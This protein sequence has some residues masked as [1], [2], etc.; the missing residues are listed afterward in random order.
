MNALRKTPGFD[1]GFSFFSNCHL[2]GKALAVVSLLLLPWLPIRPA[3]AELSLTPEERAWLRDHPVL[4]HAPDP[5]YAPFEFRDADGRIAGMATDT[6][7]R[8]ARL[9]GVHVESMATRSWVH[10]LEMVK[11]RQADLVTVATPTEDRLIHLAFTR[12][13]AIFPDLLLLRQGAPGGYEMSWLAGKTLAGIEGWAINEAVRREHPEIRFR[14]LPDVKSVLTAVS[15][16]EVDGALLNRATAGYWTERLRITNLR[17]GGETPFV[18][19]LGL[20][21]R[22]DWPLLRDLLDKALEELGQEELL[23]IQARWSGGLHESRSAGSWLAWLGVALLLTGLSGGAWFMHRRWQ[24]RL[25][26]PLE[27]PPPRK[28]K[29][30]L[31]PLR[32]VRPLAHLH[33]LTLAAGLGGTL[34]GHHLA[35]E[36]AVNALKVDFDVEARAI[37]HDIQRR[38]EAYRRILRGVH[39][40]FDAAG[41]VD[42][43]A[44]RRYVAR[45]QLQENYPGIQ[46]LGFMP[47]LAADRKEDVVR[48]VREEGFADFDVWPSGE[49]TMHAPVLYLEPMEGGHLRAFGHDLLTEPVLRSA[50]EQARDTGRSAA[51]GKTTLDREDTGDNRTGFWVFFPIY[52]HDQ[53][54]ASV[55]ERRV[56]LVGW[57]YAA[58]RMRDLMAD[59][60]GA[61]PASFDLEIH[62]CA[63]RTPEALL[64]DSDDSVAEGK[65]HTALFTVSRVIDIAKR[66]WTILVSSRKEFEAGLDGRR[67][68][69]ILAGGLIATGLLTLVTWLL[70]HGERRARQLATRMTDRLRE[71]LVKNERLT[72]IMND[73]EAYIYI[74]DRQRRY[75]YANR[76]TLELFGCSAA[77]L[78]GKKDEDFFATGDQARLREVDERVLTTGA[79]SVTEMVVTPLQAGE[80]RVYL[81]AKRAI[82]DEAGAIWGLSGVSTD[83]TAQKQAERMLESAKRS[84]ESASRAKSEFLAAMSHEIR[85]PMNVVLGMSDLLLEGSLDPEQRRLVEVMHRSGRALL[86]VIN[87]VLDYSRLEAGRFSLIDAPFSPT[88]LVHETALLMRMAAEA[89]GLALV[90]EVAAEAP[91]RLMGDEGRLRQVLI[92]L[93]GNAVK[94]TQTGEIRL[95]LQPDP[96]H[97]DHLL[98]AV[99]DSGIGIAEEHLQRIFEHFTQADS[100]IGRRYGGTGLGLAIAHRLV[101]LM[102]GALGVE[103]QPG[104]GSRFHFSLPIRLAPPAEARPSEAVATSQPSESERSLRILLAEDSP[105]N[106]FLFVGYLKK[107][108]HGLVVVDNGEEA[109]CRIQAEPF[110]LLLTDIEMP[111]MDGYALTLAI[112]QWERASGRRPMAIGALSAHAGAE[113]AGESLAAGCDFHLSKPIGKRE[114]LA[115][116]RR[117]AM[118][119]R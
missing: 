30:P 38:M 83:I 111:R 109:L 20:A 93:L 35:R 15:L 95:N 17:S 41:Q 39:G 8:V 97:P 14:W 36:D 48:A 92:N 7:R 77:A 4:R 54:L 22:N 72:D 88:V 45:Q 76:L 100:G 40:L 65:P 51:S 84:A 44:F 12:P 107:S 23:R 104:V 71:E 53:P 33:W 26:E 101:E 116:I 114:L 46:G 10:S 67:S 52:R 112:R 58:F 61:H 78:V 55:E 62:D 34:F 43:T 103:S 13:Y 115:A 31:P 79:P 91:E 73:M 24:T 99:T 59:I 60:L 6:L 96:R 113:K 57:A 82:A 50:L 118:P 75:V 2:S 69:F 105:E 102:G 19:R 66:P 89:K 68:R 85:T 110:D 28:T 74:K 87:D 21:A 32:A 56:A 90:E 86:G 63:C 29:R 119:F 64:Y 108:P 25:R 42:R 98:F 11:N 49:R 27:L 1:R 117:V 80:A 47:M 3:L 18:Y 94:F 106:Q 5:D 9:L 16:G 70:I 81:E 37:I